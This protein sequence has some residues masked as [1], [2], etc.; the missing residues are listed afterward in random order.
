MDYRVEQTQRWLND[1]YG[2]L[3]DF[4]TLIEDGITGQATFQALIWA[5][6]YELGITPDG[7]FGDATIASLNTQYPTISQS[8][9]PDNESP[10]NIIYI[11]QGS[12]WCKGISPGGFTGIFGYGTADAIYR[13]QV[14]AG[15]TRDKIVR[16]YILQ[17]I[18][19]TDSY[20]FEDTGD[21]FDTYKHEIQ[22]GLNQYYGA[23]IGLVAPNG[24]WER[25]S[26]T[27]L[28][29]AV[30]IEWNA[31]PIDG[32]IGDGTINKS[33]MLSINTSGYTNSKRLLQWALIVNGFYPGS[34]DGI[35]GTN[36]YNALYSFQDFV[37]LS[38][39]GICGKQSWY[40]LLSS[41]GDRNRNATALDT[42]HI[43]NQSEAQQFYNAG[44]RDV[45]RYL[46]NVEGSSFEKALTA[47]ELTILKNAGLNVFPIFQTSGTSAEYFTAYQGIA[48]A[49]TAI[50]AAQ[51]FGFPPEATIYFAVDYDVLLGD[52]EDHIIPYFKSIKEQVGTLYNIGA[53]GPRYILTKLSDMEFISKSFVSD[54]S[55][56]F[57][58]NIGQKMPENWAYDQFYEVSSSSSSY[59]S[60]GYDKCIASSRKTATAPNEYIT[61]TDPVWPPVTSQNIIPI[62]KLYN[63]AFDYIDSISIYT[64]VLPTTASI[65]QIVLAYLR[66]NIYF[67]SAWDEVSGPINYGFNTYLETNYPEELEELTPSNIKLLDPFTAETI[68]VEHFAATLG[69][70]L[71][72][73]VYN[74]AP[75]DKYTNAYAGWAG[76]LLQIGG[77]LGT[78]INL[79]GVNYF[80][81]SL[82]LNRCIGYVPGEIDDLEFRYLNSEGVL[83]TKHDSGF[84]YEDLVQDI[85]AFN[86]A[87]LYSLNVTPIHVALEDYYNISS[88]VSQRYSKFEEKLL[89]EYNENSIYDVAYIFTCPDSIVASVMNDI[90]TSMFGSFDNALYGEY[91]ALAFEDKISYFKQTENND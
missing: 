82:A 88:Y 17:A 2:S 44:F 79:G 36:T 42:A 41:K 3:T 76:D 8:P 74:N 85:D 1:T 65:N 66:Q 77:T 50:N 70:H 91:L 30:Q 29:K 68:S 14:T 75:I 38:A 73:F 12:L 86:I 45:G 84:A 19:N 87:H 67:S 5:L 22:M 62:E 4:P 7:V 56:G 58:C 28:I 35:F 9:D 53:Y 11:L 48:D 57:T 83:S 55:S 39:D 61:Y 10:S 80:Y 32:I 40:S 46:T 33:P 20:S 71:T 89:A 43:F 26:Q 63:Y 60:V 34:P 64:G 51:S 27:N 72:Y 69:A 47:S 6:Q 24:I 49:R 23:Q 78:S 15:I 13:F 16:P 21:V 52:I 37:C 81:N 18:M 25:K 31:T 59:A 54:M 90:F